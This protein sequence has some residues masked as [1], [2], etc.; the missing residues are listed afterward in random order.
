MPLLELAD[1]AV[2]LLRGLLVRRLHGRQVQVAPL[3][4]RRPRRL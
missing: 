3:L 4:L 2:L 1:A